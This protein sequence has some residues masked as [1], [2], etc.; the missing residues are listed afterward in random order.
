MRLEILILERIYIEIP[1]CCESS[2]TLILKLVNFIE[3]LD[4][5]QNL[6]ENSI[7]CARNKYLFSFVLGRSVLV[8]YLTQY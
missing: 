1:T 4:L 6:H 5:K 2:V 8:G 3:L 7:G